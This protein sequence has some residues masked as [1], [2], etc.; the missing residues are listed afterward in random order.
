M[1]AHL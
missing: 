1:F